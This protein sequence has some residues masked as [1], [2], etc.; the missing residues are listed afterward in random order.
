MIIQQIQKMDAITQTMP[1]P[2]LFHLIRK[3]DVMK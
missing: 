2:I 3:G 1:G